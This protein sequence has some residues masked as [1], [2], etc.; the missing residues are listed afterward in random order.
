MTEYKQVDPEL[1]L[2]IALEEGDLRFVGVMGVGLMVP[3]V[4]G[5]KQK[6]RPKYGVKIIPLTSDAI[7][8]ETHLEFQR[9]AKDYA[10]RYNRLLL[11]EIDKTADR[12]SKAK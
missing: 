9:V 4:E 3:G 6:Y 2:K 1:E 10:E 7:E 11:K 8:G 12:S 5:Y